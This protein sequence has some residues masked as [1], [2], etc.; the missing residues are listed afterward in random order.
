MTTNRKKDSFEELMTTSEAARLCNVT[1]FTIR[2]WILE[3]RLKASKTGG[4]HHRIL[5]SDLLQFM[6]ESGMRPART[7]PNSAA[8]V[9]C[10]EYVHLTKSGGHECGKCL[11]F[12]ERSNRCFLTVREFG[13]DKV[14]C[15]K[16]CTECEYMEIYFPKEKVTRATLLVRAGS[17]IRKEKPSGKEVLTNGLYKS[18]RYFAALKNMFSRNK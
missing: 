8:T 18:G 3:N 12:K 15:G 6:K 7:A 4:R 1:R 11:V 5:R 16:D 17:N 14:R 10:W 2:N 13:P 9:F